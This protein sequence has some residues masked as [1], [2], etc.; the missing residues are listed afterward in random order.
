MSSERVPRAVATAA[1][2]GAAM[3][4]A[5]FAR[6]NAYP[7][8]FDEAWYLE[9]SYR[10]WHALVKDG[11]IAFASSWMS[12]FRFKAP[13]VSALPL[14]FYL[15]F[16]P[17]YASAVLS[18][19]PALAL[20]AASLYG[21]GR[22]FFSPAGGAL[23]AVLGLL[24]PLTVALSRTYFVET[25]LTALTAAFLWRL[26]ESDQFRREREAPV[27]GL[28]FGLGLLTKVLFPG[29]V[30]APL[31]WALWERSRDPRGPAWPTLVRPLKIFASVASLVS[32]TWYGPNLVYVTGFALSAYRGGI[33]AAYGT[34]T[35]WGLTQVAAYFNS[36][37]VEIL[38]WYTV[39]LGIG[40]GVALRRRLAGSPGLIFAATWVVPYLLITTSGLCKDQRYVAPAVPG[41]AL[42]LAG[43]LDAATLNRRGRAL[44]LT[45]AVLPLASCFLLQTFGNALPGA[46]VAVLSRIFPVRTTYGGPP[47]RT[48]ELG[49][50]ALVLHLAPR[51]PPG[52]VV[53][54]GLEHPRL[55]ANL[56]A[57]QAA[58]H[59]LPL[60]FIHYGHMEGDLRR[61]LIRLIE[62]DAT[63]IFFIDGMPAGEL[64]PMVPA[65]DAALRAHARGNRIPF[66]K[67]GL[68]PISPGV[69]GE[70][71]ERTGPIR[72]SL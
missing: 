63:H 69:T 37:A 45:A 48:G 9:V 24:M 43:L 50:E 39:L 18:H 57:V 19:I 64:P 28:L 17:S 36:I 23:A 68:F 54:A 10:F 34:P 7:P 14:P 35:A 15:A 58:R 70:L 56:L 53:A 41:F 6:A 42:A 29:V 40:L 13:L 27:L 49:L 5:W 51:I 1:F 20:L 62:K 67:V 47:R 30:A 25:W 38:S 32:L 8:A 3:A 61:V 52:S 55:N 26:A 59:A 2:L 4:L 65:V 46:P 71:W 21:L 66:R 44:L 16:G 11:P 12:A 60:S 22:R 72:M 31:A 33:G